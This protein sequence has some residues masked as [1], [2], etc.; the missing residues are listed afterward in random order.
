MK[1]KYDS[2]QIPIEKTH[3]NLIQAAISR[4]EE[5]WFATTREGKGASYVKSSPYRTQTN[6]TRTPQFPQRRYITNRILKPGASNSWL[7]PPLQVS[8]ASPPDRFRPTADLIFG[9]AQVVRLSAIRGQGEGRLLCPFSRERLARRGTDDRHSTRDLFLPSLSLSS[10][11]S[12]LLNL[13]NEMLRH[14]HC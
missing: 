4:G 9:G 5:S 6:F 2:S 1:C 8:A 11:C 12:Y 13:R 10:S 14:Y 7:R 3:M